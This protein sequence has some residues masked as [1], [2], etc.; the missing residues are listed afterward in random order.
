M[1]YEEKEVKDK[2]QKKVRE[3]NSIWDSVDDDWVCNLPAQLEFQL[4]RETTT[5]L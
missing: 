4:L 1:F 2:H 3:G 5:S